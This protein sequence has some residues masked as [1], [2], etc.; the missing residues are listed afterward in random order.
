MIELVKSSV[1]FYEENHT[2]FLGDKQLNGITGMIG[3]QLFPDKYKQIPES[4]LRRAA[5]K[6]SLI[7]DQCQFADATGI[8]ESVEAKNYLAERKNAGYEALANEYTVS[9]N[10]YFASKIDCVWQKDANIS[11]AD[12][13][14]TYN[15]D[16]EYLSWQLSIYAYLFE[17][18]NPL[19]KVD[20][21]FGIWLRDTKS[22]LVN[23]ERKPD[24][25]VR[26]LMECEIKGEQYHSLKLASNVEKQLLPMHLV[27]TIIEIEEQAK[28]ISEIQNDYKEKVKAAM[29]EFGVKAWD[30]GRLRVSYT[31]PCKTVSFDSKKFQAD[32]AELYSKYLRTTKK[33]DSIR[34]TIREE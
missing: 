12:I 34:I 33:S 14:T 22:E 30:A 26:R 2:Y 18:Q 23:I 15:I 31:P 3:R 8:V 5:E 13:K 25:D 29:K 1:A 7:H 24:D 20:K 11:I 21:L 19:L 4:I 16:K 17:L 6:G 32:H 27:D 9:D 28:Y 10:E